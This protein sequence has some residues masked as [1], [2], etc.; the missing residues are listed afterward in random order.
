[1]IELV[2][3]E[4][5]ESV[6]RCP[7]V[8]GNGRNRRKA[9]AWRCAD[10]YAGAGLDTAP[11]GIHERRVRNSLGKCG[12]LRGTASADKIAL[13]LDDDAQAPIANPPNNTNRVRARLNT[14]AMVGPLTN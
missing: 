4:S 6:T 1:M 14:F 10:C 7:T 2:V 8:I 13:G 12:Q 11:T 9:H 5:R 3:N